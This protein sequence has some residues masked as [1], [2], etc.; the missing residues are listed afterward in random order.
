MQRIVQAWRACSAAKANCLRR[1][2]VRRAD[3]NFL[4][5]F[6]CSMQLTETLEPRVLLTELIG[7]D[8]GPTGDVSP[9]NWNSSTGNA[10]KDFQLFD[11]VDESGTTT[12]VDLSV[13]FDDGLDAVLGSPSPDMTQIPGHSNS[14]SNIDGVLISETSITFT[15]SDLIPS[16]SYEV[17]VIGGDHLTAYSQEVTVT[18]QSTLPAFT[19][20][21]DRQFFVNSEPGGSTV[22]IGT[23]GLQVVADGSGQIQVQVQGTSA[24]DFAVIPAIGIREDTGTVEPPPT[25]AD[26][27]ANSFNVTNEHVADGVANISF[28]IQN[29]GTS[30]TSAFDTQIV[31]SPNAVLGDGD[32]QIVAGSLLTFGG[33]DASVAASRNFNLTLDRTALYAHAVS[34]NPSGGVVGTPSADFSY[35]FLVID[36][37]DSVSEDD[38]SNNSGVA[39]G[40]DGDRIAYFPWDKNRNGVVEPL[41]AVTTIQAIGTS[42]VSS[43]FDGNGIVSPF[44]A[45]SASERIGYTLNAG[46]QA[47]LVTSVIAGQQVIQASAQPV[48]AYMPPILALPV[49]AANVPDTLFSVVRAAIVEEKRV[50]VFAPRDAELEPPLL[51]TDDDQAWID[52]SFS[53]VVDWLSV[54]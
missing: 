20:A 39:L 41:E 38:E 32:D 52:D 4:S 3:R 14:L 48:A 26:L 1:R 37:N 7:I 2:R 11:L 6:P 33:L 21:W 9:A 35:L 36:A 51:L 29:V 19:Q 27:L 5:R 8:F 13:R 50:T 34:Q 22:Q 54:I 43:D 42:D 24:L 45:L 31:W 12:S 53:T 47:K 46:V 25:G 10:G 16:E 44:E 18:G 30:A 49:T 15:F 17:F 28:T 23:Q 40:V